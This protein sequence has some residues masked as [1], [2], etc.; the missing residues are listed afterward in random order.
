MVNGTCS[1]LRRKIK[2]THLLM[3]FSIFITHTKKIEETLL[4]MIE[5]NVL[6]LDCKSGLLQRGNATFIKKVLLAQITAYS[7]LQNPF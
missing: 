7:H 2:N 4:L 5:S 3:N 6:D 1:A